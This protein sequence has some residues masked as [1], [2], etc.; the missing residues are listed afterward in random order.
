MNAAGKLAKIR[1][2]VPQFAVD[3][4]ALR[5]HLSAG[6]Y[7]GMDLEPTELSGPARTLVSWHCMGGGV[8]SDGVPRWRLIPLKHLVNH[9]PDGARQGDPDR[10]GRITVVTGANTGPRQTYEN[11]GDLDALQLLMLF[12]Y[13]DD[14]ARL[15]AQRSGGVAGMAGRAA[16]GVGQGPAQPTGPGGAGR[17]RAE[18]A[19]RLAAAPARHD[20]AA[21]T[22]AACATTW[23]WRSGR[24]RV[25]PR[26]WRPRVT[27][28]LLDDLAVAN[29]AYYDSLEELVAKAYPGSTGQQIDPDSRVAPGGRD[30]AIGRG[31]AA[32]AHHGLVGVG[33]T[34]AR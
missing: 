34:S 12:G 5:E 10:P 11:Y 31:A 32:A 25:P 16:A 33:L 20:P 7:P 28:A 1:Q 6:G 19:G 8:D 4:P 22:E 13:A 23:R 14:A 17:S 18:P 24:A 27:D 29:V 15:V 26:R 2:R 30:A 21:G 3:E 9:H